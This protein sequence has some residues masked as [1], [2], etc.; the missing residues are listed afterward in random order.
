MKNF[1]EQDE[2]NKT[3]RTTRTSQGCGPP[4]VV[5]RPHADK[6]AEYR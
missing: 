5:P 4:L 1:I 2:E 3:K 6:T